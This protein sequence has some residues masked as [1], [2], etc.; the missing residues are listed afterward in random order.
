MEYQYTILSKPAEAEFKDKGSKFIAYAYPFKNE[1]ELKPILEKLRQEHFKARHFC[2]AYRLGESQDVFR[3]NDD[4]EPSGSA[5]KPILNAI[6][7]QEISDILIVVVR[8]F[9]GTLLG[10]PGLINAY[11]TAALMTLEACERE[12]K[13]I[14]ERYSFRFGFDNLNDL[15]RIVKDFDLKIIT[16]E[17]HPDCYFELEMKKNQSEQIIQLF[18]DF[19]AFEITEL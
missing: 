2:F 16:Q 17:Y 4:G 12:T 3:A 1:K 5:G 9:G 13:F 8:Y 11:K 7:S 19:R 18:E 15:M 10:V 14:T 6:L